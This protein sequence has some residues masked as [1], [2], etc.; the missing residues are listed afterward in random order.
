MK[1]FAISDIHG[2]NETFN[3]LLEKIKLKKK[4]K[5]FL[6]GDYID[7][8]PDSKG[9]IDTILKLRK[10][11][12]NTI[13]LKGNHDSYVDVETGS[14][15]WQSWMAQGGKQTLKSFG[16]QSFSEID[17]KYRK[18]FKSLEYYSS[19]KK[20]YMVHAGFDFSLEKPFK[21]TY[22][23]MW[24]R[25]MEYDAEKAKGKKIVHGHTPQAMKKAI[26]ANS[27]GSPLIN[28][29]F[30]CIYK[31]K[32][33]MGYLCCYELGTDNYIVQKNVDNY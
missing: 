2:C 9:V 17:K 29:D 21:D 18:F 13:C 28:I 30:G 5:L 26:K 4:H 24:I 25:N 32:T 8:G 22:S 23:M 33:G 14:P 10:S 1:A 20:F 11:G 7:R 3:F 12:Y 15:A 16:V 31:K 6:L 27:N 19:H